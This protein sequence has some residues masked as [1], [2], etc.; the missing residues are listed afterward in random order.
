MANVTDCDFSWTISVKHLESL[1]DH[2]LS[3]LSQSIST[4]IKKK[5]DILKSLA[6]TWDQRGTHHMR[7][8]HPNWRRNT[9]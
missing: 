6:V 5:R 9:S 8:N 2:I 3:A 1:G 7:L 4:K